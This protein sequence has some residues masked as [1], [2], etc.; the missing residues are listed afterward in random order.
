MSCHTKIG[1]M[2]RS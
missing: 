2:K 1:V